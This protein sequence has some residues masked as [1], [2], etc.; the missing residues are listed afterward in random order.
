LWEAEEAT[1]AI[2][3]T[4]GVCYL[5]LDKSAAKPTHEPGERFTLGKARFVRRGA[6]A[7]IISCGGI[8]GEVLSAAE[9]LK[10]DGILPTIVSL[11]TVKPIDREALLEIVKSHDAIITVEEHGLAGGLGSAIAEVLIDAGEVPRR[12]KRLAIGGDAYVSV[13]GSQE[14]L[15]KQCGLDGPSIAEEVRQAV[16]LQ[17]TV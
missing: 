10:S 4:H 3:A 16:A 7:A 1:K 17:A 6:H 14:Y 15:R 12:F 5:R 11:H 13:V 9:E 2:A 8:L